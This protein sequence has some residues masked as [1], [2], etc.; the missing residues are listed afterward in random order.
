VTALL[1]PSKLKWAD[2]VEATTPL[3]TPWAKEE[4]ETRSRAIQAERRKIRAE[5]RPE[6]EM[7]ALFER[8]RDAEE[9][10][11]GQERYAGKVGAF[12]GANY[13]ARGFYRPAADCIMFTRDRV[14]FCPVCRRALDRVIDLYAQR[15]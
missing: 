6:S 1:E 11:L 8:E 10:L 2:L 13:E 14:P 9:R 12:E 5:R 4:F 15:R 7:D 3:P